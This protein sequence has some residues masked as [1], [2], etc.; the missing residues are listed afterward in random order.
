[1]SQEEKTASLSGG[2]IQKVVVARECSN[3][4]YLL[5]ANQ[6]TRGVDIGAAK[7]IHEKIFGL[8]EK[9]RGILLISAD[10]GE[11]LNV[12][13]SLIIIFDGKITAW[14]KDMKDL[15][16][17][18]LGLYMLGLKHMEGKDE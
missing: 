17:K 16:E 18:E 12:C 4:P 10:L 6:P 2:N 14:F 13:S 7:L 5:I 1:V 15:D 9:G 11:L 8:S 3:N